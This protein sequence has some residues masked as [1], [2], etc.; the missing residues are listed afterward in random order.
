MLSHK[1][2]GVRG[3]GLCGQVFVDIRQAKTRGVE[4]IAKL[5]GHRSITSIDEMRSGLTFK[6]PY[7]FRSAPAAASSY[8]QSFSQS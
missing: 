8:S 5:I 2:F 7:S 3:L 6:K 4:G 1:A